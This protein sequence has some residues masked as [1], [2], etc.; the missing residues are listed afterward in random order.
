MSNYAEITTKLIGG[1]RNGR[2]HAALVESEKMRAELERKVANLERERDQLRAMLAFAD[3]RINF[4]LDR[5]A[6]PRGPKC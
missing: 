5:R 2:T 6:Q 3:A 4:G 1:I